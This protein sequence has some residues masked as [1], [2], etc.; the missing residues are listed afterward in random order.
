MEKYDIEN[1]ISNEIS[2]MQEYMTV[3]AGLSVLINS[4]KENNNYEFVHQS[5]SRL[6]KINIELAENIIFWSMSG[7]NGKY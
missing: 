7:A 3:I 4:E 6:K 5:L 2:L 1:H